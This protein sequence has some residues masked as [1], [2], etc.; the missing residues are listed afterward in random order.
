[1]KTKDFSKEMNNLYINRFMKIDY[2]EN[3]DYCIYIGALQCGKSFIFQSMSSDSIHFNQK[4]K[5]NH[6]NV[7][8]ISTIYELKNILGLLKYLEALKPKLNAPYFM[9]NNFQR[10]VL[11]HINDVISQRDNP[12][13]FSS[14]NI[15][16]ILKTVL[17]SHY[18]TQKFFRDNGIVCIERN[19]LD[20]PAGENNVECIF[21]DEIELYDLN[22]LKPIHTKLDYEWEYERYAETIQRNLLEIYGIKNKFNF[23]SLLEN[24]DET[25]AKIKNLYGF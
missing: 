21:K 16:Y 1:M 2:N 25:E 7:L 12:Y 3:E 24:I 6:I 13:I 18:F 9:S 20:L 15:K 11:K 22:V 10:S 5:T 23:K 17:H 14:S 8:S 4:L 19:L